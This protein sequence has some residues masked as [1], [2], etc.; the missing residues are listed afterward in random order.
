MFKIFQGLRPDTLVNEWLKDY[1]D[2]MVIDWCY[3]N[4]H[5]NGYSSICIEY[6]NT[7]KV[8]KDVAK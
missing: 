1:P 2:V 6:E 7:K 3:V 8:I 5:T 4:N